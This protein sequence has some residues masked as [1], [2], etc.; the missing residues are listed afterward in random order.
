M[1]AAGV[2]IL[3]GC[4]A[5]QSAQEINRLRSDVSLLDQRVGQLERSSVK[6]SSS[7]EWPAQ[8]QAPGAAASVATP[9]APRTS[10][11][12]PILKPSKKEIQ[13]ALKNAGVYQGPV[14]GKIG[15]RTRDAIKE[16]QRIQ[17][18]KVDGVVG[19]QTWEKLSPYLGQAS[20][21]SGELHAAEILK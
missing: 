21:D 7:A 15:P 11:G 1:T 2:S 20:I 19:R 17:G 4:A 3:T 18:L 9:E 10:S 16:F 14:D 5:G 12:V 6:P 13:Q 8:A